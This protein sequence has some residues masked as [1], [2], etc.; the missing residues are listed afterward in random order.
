VEVIPF[1]PSDGPSSS[2]YLFLPIDGDPTEGL[3]PPESRLI[4][5]FD[6]HPEL[7]PHIIGVVLLGFW[8][9]LLSKLFL[10]LGETPP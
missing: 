10:A 1:S 2:E 6:P 8:F 5:P 3:F 4:S 9:L 7:N